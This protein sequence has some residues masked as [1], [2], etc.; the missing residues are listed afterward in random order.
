MITDVLQYYIFTNENHCF[1]KYSLSVL[2]SRIT[3]AWMPEI[4]ANR[5]PVNDDL[6]WETEKNQDVKD[7]E[8]MP[9]K[10]IE[11]SSTARGTILHTYQCE[12][13]AL[14]RKRNNLQQIA[15]SDW[16]A[17]G[18]VFQLFQYGG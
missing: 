7:Q 11:Q 2:S 5:Y 1:L 17:H 4:S 13:I 16:T 8:C 6:S 15:A 14:S 9:D 3:A 18:I 10:T 12:A